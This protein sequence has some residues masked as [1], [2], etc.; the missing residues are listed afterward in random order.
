MLGRSLHSFLLKLIVANLLRKLS[1]H[2]HSRSLRSLFSQEKI[3][4]QFN[5]EI[6]KCVLFFIYN[7]IYKRILELQKLPGSYQRSL[8]MRF[9]LWGRAAIIIHP[10]YLYHNLGYN[11]L[12]AHSFRYLVLFLLDSRTRNLVTPNNFQRFQFIFYSRNPCKH[13]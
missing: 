2:T 8:S 6:M 10:S 5:S 1:L 4:K 7:F 12:C 11:S 9:S 3:D 13:R